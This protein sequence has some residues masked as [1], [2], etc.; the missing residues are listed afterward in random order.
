M[1]QV[2]KKSKELDHYL[3]SVISGVPKKLDNFIE[4]SDKSITYY[5][6]NWATDV[7][8]NFTEKQSE[9]IFKNMSKYINNNNLQFFQRKNK[10][11]EIGTW[12][13]Y[14]ENEPESITSYDYIV[15]RRANG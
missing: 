10:N 14:G 11:I 12:S 8:D 4:G 6:G 2:R 13:E 9:K 15:I 1:Q 3:K 7:A 5:T